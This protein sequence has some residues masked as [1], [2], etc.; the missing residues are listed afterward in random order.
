MNN[1][2]ITILR[3]L[4]VKYTY[5]YA[6]KIY[7]RHPFK[8][9]LY[10]LSKML[11]EYNISNASFIIKEPEA[12]KS[13]TCPFMTQ[14]GTNFALI[15]SIEMQSVE[16]IL[17][18]KKYILPLKEFVDRSS[19]VVLLFERSNTTH[20]PSYTKNILISLIQIILFVSFIISILYLLLSIACKSQI[21]YLTATVFVLFFNIIGLT[22]SV[23]TVRKEQRTKNKYVDKFCTFFK[24]SSCDDLI[25]SNGGRFLGSFP[26]SCVGVAYFFANLVCILFFGLT[27]ICV[28][29]INL[30]TILFTLWSIYYQS[31]KAKIFCPLCITVC[32][33]C[34]GN[35]IS[36]L[37]VISV[38][39]FPISAETN[40]FFSALSLYGILFP[41]GYYILSSKIDAWT[42]KNQYKKMQQFKLRDSTLKAILAFES[43]YDM[44]TFR[45][46]IVV[47]NPNGKI[48]LS[49]L[50]NPHCIPCSKMHVRLEKIAS[51]N[52]ELRV[53]YIF[54]S[55]TD[56]LE[57][58]VY[59]LIYN[60]FHSSN[61]SSILDEWFNTGK[62][63]RH[64]FYN[65][66]PFD[67]KDD[68]TMEE[69]HKHK[70]WK[71]CSGL[72]AT[73]T[74]LVNGKILPSDYSV[75]DL[76]FITSL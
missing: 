58:S 64:C 2:L 20:E 13:F 38:N 29:L 66:Y 5:Y 23:L 32:A 17:D 71:E 27:N 69:I 43:L 45:S 40:Y 62:D 1:S 12:F 72:T 73:P 26:L 53:D 7:S 52:K 33:S 49:V 44:H 37:W 9:T 34:W 61:F 67:K 39:D 59:C 51:Q 48:H 14:I 3:A 35:V 55:F 22:A 60:Y 41:V 74:I 30:S 28:L 36:V 65:K 8:D 19:G 4:H 6:N 70:K 68:I 16:F 31:V 56:E 21:Q 57:D 46:R 63:H 11:D 18:G 75:E 76:E 24:K 10:G 25:N 42:I 50:T 15:R 54:T 47:A